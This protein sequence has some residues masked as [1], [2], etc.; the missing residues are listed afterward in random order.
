MSYNKNNVCK[1]GI[2]LPEEECREL[3]WCLNRLDGILR[4]DW[5]DLVVSLDNH[6]LQLEIKKMKY[7]IKG[8][9]IQETPLGWKATSLHGRI[10]KHFE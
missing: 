3:A 10:V 9:F 2:T 5:I 8:Y 7:T 6:C 1:L 4:K